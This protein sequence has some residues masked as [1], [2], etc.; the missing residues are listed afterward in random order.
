MVTPVVV[1]VVKE[2]WVAVVGVG[3]M[4]VRWW[5]VVVAGLSV[6]SEVG[7]PE[8]QRWQGRR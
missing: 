5:E 6:V 4:V 2:Q 7:V 3:P 8:V 1:L